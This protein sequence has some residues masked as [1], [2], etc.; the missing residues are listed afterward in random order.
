VTL[1]AFW[2]ADG[3]IDGDIIE[4]VRTKPGQEKER[5]DNDFNTFYREVIKLNQDCSFDYFVESPPLADLFAECEWRDWVNQDYP[6]KRRTGLEAELRARAVADESL[7][8]TVCGDIPEN[9]LFVDAVTMNERTPWYELKESSR[10][11][12]TFKL[13]P[14]YGYA[15]NDQNMPDA[16]KPYC[17]DMKVRFCCAKKMRAEWG[18]WGPWDECSCTCG[19][20]SQKR[21]RAC[22]IKK[23]NQE[24]CFGNNAGLA[25][26]KSPTRR[27]ALV[28]M[29]RQRTRQ[30]FWSRN[31]NAKLKPVQF[32]SV[33]VP[34]A[35][36][37][38][39]PSHVARME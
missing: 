25:S 21:N 16:E 4:T 34:G 29:Q 11:Y 35:H 26:S 32:H 31:G 5:P 37:L 18:A 36:G 1:T 15:C 23:P 12:E 13:T 17:Q 2:E 28:T 19:G 33:G 22:I 3:D 38:H 7:S 10:A 9:A 30:D 24:T 6:N 14:F 20:G 8:K 39:A 27:P